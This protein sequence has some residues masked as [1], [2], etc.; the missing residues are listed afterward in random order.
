MQVTKALY[1]NLTS[2][3]HL[4]LSNQQHQPPAHLFSPSQQIITVSHHIFLPFT[5]NN[6]PPPA[7]LS[8]L[9]TLRHSHR[10]SFF[11]FFSQQTRRRWNSTVTLEFPFCRSQTAA[12]GFFSSAR[13]ASPLSHAR[14]RQMKMKNNWI[15]RISLWF[16]LW[17]RDLGLVLHPEP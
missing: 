11:F 17:D 9:T 10:F 5:T 4:W 6:H 8:L 14:R 7:F 16:Q 1:Q 13:S 2:S 3:S 12:S 15:W